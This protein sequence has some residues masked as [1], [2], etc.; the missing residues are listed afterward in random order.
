MNPIEK[1][2][3]NPPD[4]PLVLP[5]R[6]RVLVVALRR[7]GDVLFATP[8][9]ASIRRAFPQA[10][11]DAL[12]FADTAGMLAGNRD[13]DHVVTMPAAR[14]TM[15]SLALALRLFK[16]YDLAVSTQ[17]GDRPTFFALLAGRRHVGPID[18]GR[19]GALRQMALSR[20]VPNVPGL[21][22]LEEM[23]RLA[24]A[25]GIKRVARLVCPG[26]A[27][28]RRFVAGPY[29][30]IHAAPQFTY[31]RWTRDGWRALAA[32]LRGRGLA[33]LATGGP[34]S[35]ERA[36]LDDIWGDDGAVTRLDGALSWP[37]LTALL[38]K[39]RLYVGPDTSITHLAA[40]SGCP[41]VALYGPTDPRRWGP[42]PAA[43]LDPIWEAAGT[44]QRRGNVWLVQNP[45]PCLPC[46]NEG[47]ERHLTSF[48]RCLDALEP[49][50]VLH[51]VDEALDMALDG[52]PDMA[53]DATPDAL[54]DA[55][56]DAS[57]PAPLQGAAEAD[58]EVA[59][60]PKGRYG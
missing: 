52:A 36:F 37:E 39:A 29:A 17:S 59:R 6:P 51:A 3:E 7:L 11:I 57:V 58:R 41:T 28:P 42:V 45:L 4:E 30:V 8:L 26:G 1:S 10:R 53:L 40:A 60:P 32:G 19:R 27:A 46:Q 31:K 38:A 48:S 33:I 16:R 15:A 23:L 14:G 49:A 56:L 47:C 9:I 2:S 12:V 22:R 24:D 25:L 50:Q 13:L 44:I 35:A 20:A 43:G 18:G 34:A 55:A 5:P 21:H 54:S